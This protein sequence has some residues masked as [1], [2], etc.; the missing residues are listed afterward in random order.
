MKLAGAAAKRFLAKPASEAR[1]V[2]LFGPNRAMIEESALTLVAYA[3]GPSPDPL[4]ITRLSEEELR[5]DRALLS[6]QLAAQSL[7]GGPRILRVRADGDSAAESI[8]DAVSTLD[9]GAPAAAFM[10][11]ES[12]ELAARSK[13]RVAFENAAKSFAIAFYQDDSAALTEFAAD[14]LKASGVKLTE[15]AGGRLQAAL[16]GDRALIRSEV[17][18]LA[19]FAYGRSEPLTETEIAALLAVEGEAALDEA[20]LAAAAGDAHSAIEDFHRAGAGGI[21]AIKALERRLLRLQEAR[22]AIDAGAAPVDAAAK[23]RPP[24]FWKERDAFAGHLRAWSPSRLAAALDIL[25]RAQ[26]RAMTAGAPQ[27]LIA[28]EAFRAV[29]SLAN[30]R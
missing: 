24:V 14:L 7:L 26:L 5:R 21:T 17:E 18:K 27:D 13:I 16:P 11:V 19:L 23:L 22:A 3:L 25:W 8:V 15:E 30:R 28:A 2:L 9:E 6:D 10:I 4:A 20:T 1:A 12:G 29:A